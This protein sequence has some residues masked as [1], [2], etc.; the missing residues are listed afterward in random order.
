MEKAITTTG[1][2]VY[3]HTA[4]TRGQVSVKQENGIRKPNEGKFGK[5]YK[6][7]SNNPRSTRFCFVSYYIYE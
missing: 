1:K 5:G 4:L 6:V 7:L 3:H 2:A